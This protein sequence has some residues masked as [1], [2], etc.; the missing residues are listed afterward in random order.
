MAIPTY[1]APQIEK[2]L[3]KITGI[4]R[5]QSISDDVCSFCGK[6]ANEFKD[7]IS[8]TEFKISGFCQACQDNFFDRNNSQS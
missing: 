7:T 6:P 4:D 3:F 1:K 2:A 8:Q 5:K